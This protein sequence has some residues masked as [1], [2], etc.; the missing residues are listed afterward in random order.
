[1]ISIEEARELLNFAGD[2]K[3]FKDLGEKQLEST[4]ALYNMIRDGK[5]GYL[6]D[7]VGMGKTYVALG[8]ISLMRY[9]NPSLKVLYILP[10][11]NVLDKWL[12]KEYPNF[13][14]DN[15]KIKNHKVKS[16]D[17][18]P[19][20]P[21]VECT[22][23]I[24]L[25]KY[26]CTG[27][28]GDFF[29]KM[30]SFSFPLSEESNE[31]EKK[32]KH[33]KELIPSATIDLNVENKEDV[34]LQ[35]AE[36]I[37]KVLPFFDLVLIDEAHNFRKSMNSS[38]RNKYLSIILGTNEE[39]NT[40]QKVDNVLLL[41]ATPFDRDI[42]QL[43]NQLEM[44]G[45]NDYANALR[46]AKDDKAKTVAVLQKFMSRR[47][48]E[49]E[50]GTKLYTRNQYRIEERSEAAIKLETI[51]KKLIVALVQKK[52]GELLDDDK[53]KG[54]YQ[55]G[56]LA[57]FES[58]LPSSKKSS[59]QVEA[60]FDD[61]SAGDVTKAVDSNIITYLH[62]SY[63]KEFNETSLP[64]PKMDSVVEKYAKDSFECGNKHII[65]VRRV[66]SVTDLKTKFD[67]YYDE[68]IEEYL[69][70]NL[71]VKNIQLETELKIYKEQNISK[72]SDV[73]SNDE[74][75]SNNFFTYFFR[76]KNINSAG[77]PFDIKNKINTVSKND[78]LINSFEI[79][80]F[81]IFQIEVDKK[82]LE[83]EVQKYSIKKDK[84]SDSLLK[85]EIF[86]IIQI[87]Y[88]KLIESDNNVKDIVTFYMDKF[89]IIMEDNK[90]NID[91][92][93]VEQYLNYKSFFSYFEDIFETKI[94]FEDMD[95][96]KIYF[97]SSLISSVLRL[98]HGIIDL[99]IAYS[100]DRN[101]FVKEFV[102]LL[103]DQKKEDNRFSS[104]NQIKELIVQKDLVI[105]NNFTDY[106]DSV[107]T[108]N[109]YISGILSPLE[110]II[111]ARGG[112][113]TKSA[114][115]RKFR[116]PGYP[117]ILIST[118]VLQ[119][120]EDLHTFC[121]SVIHY[122]LSG[123][124]IAIEQKNGRVDRIGSLGQRNLKASDKIS[125]DNKLKVAFP[126]LQE[127]IE[128]VQIHNLA[129]NLNDF[130]T[131]IDSFETKKIDI[132]NDA[133]AVNKI[134]GIVKQIDDKLE[135]SF[136]ANSYLIKPN[137]KKED[138]IAIVDRDKKK[139]EHIINYL[140]SLSLT[141]NMIKIA[142]SSSEFILRVEQQDPSLKTIYSKDELLKYMHEIS[143][144]R[145]H[146]TTVSEL[147]SVSAEEISFKVEYN[148]EMLVGDEEITQQFEVDEVL[149]RIQS[150]HL[151]DT[152]VYTIDELFKIV[153]KKD[154]SD[155]SFM[156]N[157]KVSL[158]ANKKMSHIEVIF[159]FTQNGVNRHQ[160]VMLEIKDGYVIFSSKAT[161]NNI[162][163]SLSSNE[164][165]KY[166]WD[167]NRS[168]DIVEFV[169]DNEGAII[170]RVVFPCKHIHNK[171]ILYNAY[172]LACEADH[173]EQILHGDDE[174]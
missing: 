62:D 28:Y 99:Y 66:Q 12:K 134:S 67:K 38:S 103:I 16:F 82:A 160:K 95:I 43:I 18:K 162:V 110:P 37:N 65:F 45:M 64:H 19:A 26:S 69:I 172:V 3:D 167:R 31:L 104:Y 15:F 111:G 118:N 48:N 115:A 157:H 130:I 98:G 87:A 58:Y 100:N 35:Y 124:P 165:I 148:I 56:M 106:K 17:D 116:M 20:V 78:N 9:I 42:N 156:R 141:D 164:I 127:S 161:T 147:K 138:L 33:L 24:D 117:M 109:N 142:R 173:L 39:F 27:Y 73:D 166:T 50:I 70:N 137:S 77:T 80:W 129:I 93:L 158:Q 57:S 1:M 101:N 136:N 52:V 131:S 151:V 86:M 92:I 150:E 76:G 152:Q 170:G 159:D 21:Q 59:T 71:N 22:N 72:K 14:R 7:E 133:D 44:V 88:L 23:L 128:V 122:G 174:Y 102:N 63:T 123:S 54:Q 13:L 169:V 168:I 10:K 47:L 97:I 132:N 25:I 105:R 96:E 85:N 119:E 120:G 61:L 53:F 144:K 140:N 89:N 5:L 171:E 143:Y 68:W 153:I 74:D 154:L 2:N 121:D 107:K 4:V 6:A 113:G 46:A 125:D 8:V 90:N 84:D 30:S 139:V 41:S 83:K 155:Y 91:N 81:H 55:T 94:I 34:K 145:Y 36:N 114:I 60:E 163:Q 146:R 32:V 40:V 75:S 126:F 29:I 49:L 112:S 108:V 51:D 79:N 149:R 11:Q 135:S